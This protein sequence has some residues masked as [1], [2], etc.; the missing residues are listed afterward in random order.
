MPE[1]EQKVPVGTPTAKEIAGI[2][3][4]RMNNGAHFGFIQT[5]CERIEKETTITA[6]PIAKAAADALKAALKEEDAWLAVSRKSD[7]T[8]E[9]MAA[10]SERDA[11]YMGY[12]SAVKGFTRSSTPEKAKAATTLWNNLTAHR[13]NSNMQL[14]RETFLIVNLTDD[15][16][17]KYATEVQK[18]GLKP[19]VE[20]LKAANEKVKQLL[21]DRNNSRVSQTAGALRTARRASDAA[22]LWLA[23][24]VNSLVV[25]DNGTAKCDAFIDYMNVVIKRYKE[26]VIPSQKKKDAPTDPKDPKQPK[27]PKQP[28]DP[29]D[30]KQPK[31]PKEPKQPDG[32]KPKDPKKPD[33][34]GKKPEKPG[35]G[36]GDPDI[37]LPEE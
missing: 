25:L 23:R 8:E 17:K 28:K 36:D 27:E 4:I 31:E 9:I 29:K 20:S 19:Y 22:Y 10:D 1:S 30:P 14:E 5:V 7:L 13:I 32:E 35:G 24:V 3:L 15:C 18:L 12:R 21:D 33:E 34:G 11:L 6:N 37:H 26:Q 2:D 16:E